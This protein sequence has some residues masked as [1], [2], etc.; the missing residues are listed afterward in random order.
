M[1][2]LAILSRLPLGDVRVYP[3]AYHKLRF[4]SRCRIALG[5][6]VATAGGPIRV[7]NV[8]LDTRINSDARVAQLAPLL[9]ALG[10]IDGSQLIGGDFNTM[11]IYWW[12][13]MWPLPN[14]AQ[15]AAA[16]RAE[17]GNRG[18]HTPFTGGR[19]TFKFMNLPIQLDWIFLK[20]LEAV[21]WDVDDVPITDHRGIW[22]RVATAAAPGTSAP[23][24]AAPDPRR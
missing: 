5:A 15:Q 13:T 4:K 3:L 18:F 9:D 2:G 12:Q 23:R 19:P 21:A 6:T 10:G 1:Q 24:S 17:L 11:D 14:A 7:T 16:V 8:H 22:A 20:Q